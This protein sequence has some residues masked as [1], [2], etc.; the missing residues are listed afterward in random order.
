MAGSG[1]EWWDLLRGSGATF[2]API[3]GVSM[4]PT[5][6]PG[7]RVRIRPLPGADY[8][9]GDV[10]VCVLR[11]ELFAHRIVRRQGRGAREAVITLGD[12]RQLCDPPTRVRDILGRVE[13]ALHGNDWRPLPAPPRPAPP[14]AARC[15]GA[16]IGA[17]L[18]LHFEVARRVA[19][20]SLLLADF[21]QRRWGTA[22][23]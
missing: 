19:G 18:V 9:I 20:T 4:L 1:R 8:R 14:R 2:E 7:Q 21:V 12:N 10:V 17:C 6:A 5:L 3:R 16:L 22:R 23:G 11:D 13:S 15:H